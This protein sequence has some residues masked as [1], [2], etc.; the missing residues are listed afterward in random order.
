M[1]RQKATEPGK[2]RA[3]LIQLFKTDKTP[4]QP[5][6]IRKPYRF[7]P[8]T[9]AKKEIRKY[10]NS[11]KLLIPKAAFQRLVREVVQ[12]CPQTNGFRFQSVA[13]LALQEAAEH[14]MVGILK[15]SQMAAEHSKRKTVFKSD[16]ALACCLRGETR[17]GNYGPSLAQKIR[18][19]RA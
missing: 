12:K 17:S 5:G 2:K 4:Q 11:T 10:Q 8:G 19:E 1:V 6:G 15:D 18:G 16:I 7:R 13:L 14:Y 3:E 9:I